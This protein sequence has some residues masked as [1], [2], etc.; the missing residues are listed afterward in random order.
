MQNALMADVTAE[1]VY[2]T[3]NSMPRNKS[4]GP[5][6]YTVEFFL[7]AWQIIGSLFV[8]AVQEFFHSEQ[9]LK[10]LNATTLALVP[11]IPQPVKVTDYRP[12]ACCNTVY[13]CVSKILANRLKMFLPY[14]ISP[15]QSV[16]IA[17]RRIMDNILLAQEVIKDYGRNGGNP[18]CTIK[19]D[20]KKAFDSVNWQFIL[21][22]L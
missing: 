9:L 15:N 17:G 12:I 1:E 8:S 4:P 2:K 5:D 13:K 18:R 11:K 10:Q 16:F 21:N 3:L 22:V 14:L 19:L 7:A 20:I 6:G